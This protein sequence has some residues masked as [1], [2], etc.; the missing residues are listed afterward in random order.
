MPK[1]YVLAEVDITDPALFA[2]YG[3]QVAPT[4]TAYGGRY[5]VR[6][7]EAQRMVG[8]HPARRFVVLEFP[9]LEQ[10]KAWYDSQEYKPAR[11]LRARCA[12]T[13]LFIVAGVEA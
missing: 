1:G 5:L 3:K 2:E 4:V 8:D 13:Q 9:S 7:V 11:D 12:K 6:G 10:A